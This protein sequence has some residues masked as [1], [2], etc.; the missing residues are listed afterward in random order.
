MSRAA[1]PSSTRSI[2]ERA[3]GRDLDA[4]RRAASC[5]VA[6]NAPRPTCGGPTTPS[7]PTAR[8]GPAASTVI[9]V[10]DGT[11]GAAAG[12]GRAQRGDGRPVERRW[13]A[14]PSARPAT[15]VRP[16]TRRRGRAGRRS[17]PDWDDAAGRDLGPGLR[18]LRPGA[19]RGLRPG[20]GP[21]GGCSSAS[22]STRSTTIYLGSSTG[23][24]LRHVQPTGQLELN[25]KSAGPHPL[26]PGSGRR[27]ATSPTSTSRLSM[28]SSPAGSAGRSAASTCPP[29]RYETLLPP[30]AVADLM[31][32]AYWSAGG[33]G[34]RRGPHG[35]L[36]AR[37][38]HPD[39]R[40]AVRPPGDPAQRPGRRR[41]WSA[42][43]SWPRRRPTPPSSV[44][45]NGLPLGPHRLDPRR[46]LDLSAAAPGR[47][48]RARAATPRR[49]STTSSSTARTAVGP[50]EDLV[51]GDRARAAADLPVVHPR[52]RPADPAAHRPDPR[53]RLP[54][55]GR[56]GHRRG[57]QLPLQR[58]PGR[59]A[60]RVS[61]RSAARAITLCREWNDYFTRT[62]MP[63]LRIGD[64]N[65]STV[66]KAS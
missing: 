57:Q 29:G 32:Y 42:R 59:P 24:R 63:A 58:E 21:A 36:Q 13:C 25:G 40:A 50:L 65:M 55:R 48:P 1:P 3:A 44:F 7:P 2:V 54:R 45:D 22:P 61:A 53:R 39:R 47:G 37:R 56:R 16:T 6:A 5:I 26:A 10:V 51:A 33:A 18:R 15:P 66:S 34:R 27:P 43:R 60:R 30:A 64:F 9:S 20:R 19:R 12:V 31:I 4:R 17:A 52:G 62:A 14:P 8:C 41:A 28:P 23:L 11:A 35:L 38:R 46:R 49:L